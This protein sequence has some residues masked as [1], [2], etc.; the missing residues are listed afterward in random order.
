MIRPAKLWC[1]VE[2]A[3]EAQE[4]SVVYGITLVPGF[5]AS[6][7]LWL[8]R[9]EPQHFARLAHVLLPHDY[10]NYYLTGIMAMEVSL[11]S[12]DGP[13][14]ARE[15]PPIQSAWVQCGDASGSGFFD[16][17]RRRFDAQRMAA[18]DARLASMLPPLIG[19]NQV[20]SNSCMHA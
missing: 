10:F 12:F 16:T 3:P 5:T 4:L 14:D 1:D 6:K 13:H 11:R 18:I 2:S 20:H 17:E 19:P 9:R 8:K 7:V 15:G